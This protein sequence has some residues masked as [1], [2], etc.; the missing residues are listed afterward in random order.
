MPEYVMTAK[1]NQIVTKEVQLLVTARSEEEADNKARRA[2]Q[3]YPKEVAV[4]GVNRILTKKS[5]YWIPRDI[6]ITFIREE[7]S[8]A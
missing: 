5:M 1:V 4:E 2:L 7:K 8:A 3:T 6:D